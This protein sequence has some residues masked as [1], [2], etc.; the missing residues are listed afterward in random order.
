[1]K[2][3]DTQLVLLSAASQ[4]EDRCLEL[5]P[6]LKGGAAQKV[7]SKLITNG[8]VEESRARPGMPVWRQDDEERTI[9]LRITKGGLAAIQ[10][11]DDGVDS[12]GTLATEEGE[13]QGKSSARAKS[14]GA[15]S[16]QRK[17]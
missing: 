8:L 6:N 13:Q 1:M 10:V 11:E 17:A 9:A 5:P 4:R 7:I 3:T 15:A 16:K 2:L 12:S 14:P